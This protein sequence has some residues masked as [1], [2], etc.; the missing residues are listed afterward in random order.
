MN[1]F[2]YKITVLSSLSIFL[3]V[4]AQ[5]FWQLYPQK[6]TDA[7]IL[8]LTKT[9]AANKLT[10]NNSKNNYDK[11]PT[12]SIFGHEVSK[13]NKPIINIIPKEKPI[14]AVKTPLNISLHGIIYDK[15]GNSSA[16]ISGQNFK[17]KEFHESEKLP[18]GNAVIHQISAHEVI[19]LRQGKYEK[20]SLFTADQQITNKKI[21]YTK[22][23]DNTN[24]QIISNKLNQYKSKALKNPMSLNGLINFRTKT[25]NGQFQGYILSPGKDKVLFEQSGLKPGDVLTRINGLELNTPNKIFALANQ[26][27]EMKHLD[28]GIKRNGLEQNLYF[29]ID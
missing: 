11:I 25:S 14:N 8:K 9:T 21:I 7:Q 1:R 2:I 29:S 3:F 20:M 4:L 22:K 16:I 23:N 12:Y 10:K 19:I 26:L 27:K 5:L 24:K 6:E 13:K 15:N 18:I 28:I 17:E